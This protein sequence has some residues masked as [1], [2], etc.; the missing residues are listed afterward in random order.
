M[1][2]FLLSER[3]KLMTLLF[4]LQSMPGIP[5]QNLTNCNIYPFVDFG[6]QKTV[7]IWLAI[8]SSVEN[9]LDDIQGQTNVK[10]IGEYI[11]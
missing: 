1:F 10:Q 4:C 8:V 6:A 2:Y 5:S 7:N 11:L 3:E 9:I